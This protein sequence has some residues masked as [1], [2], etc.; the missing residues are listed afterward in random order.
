M[1]QEFLFSGFGGQGVMFTGQLL[2]YT[3]MDE[4]LEVTWI[5]SYGPEMRGGTAHCFTVIGDTPIGSPIVA[6]PSV[7]IVF[8]IPSFLKYDPIIAPGGRLVV[9]SSLVGQDSERDDLEV[10]HVPATEMAESLGNIKLANMIL[11][12]AATADHPIITPEALKRGLE[13]HMPAHR[14]NLLDLNKRAVDEGANVNLA[15]G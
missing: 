12:A 2:A 6:R 15:I 7:G 11:L 5:P 4:G 13:G 3:A 14:R 1:Q 8:N 9:N 10:L